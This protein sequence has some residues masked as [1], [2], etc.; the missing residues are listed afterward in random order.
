ME[1]CMLCE[2]SE[3]DITFQKQER[4]NMTVVFMGC[5]YPMQNKCACSETGFPSDN[6]NSGNSDLLVNTCLATQLIGSGADLKPPIDLR[7]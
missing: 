2:N 7:D 4:T 1:V 6:Q 5:M 3:S